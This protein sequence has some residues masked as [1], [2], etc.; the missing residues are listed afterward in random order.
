MLYIYRRAT[1][2][3]ARAL[4]NALNGRRWKGITIPMERKARPGDYVVCWGESFPNING[5]NVLNGTPIQSKYSDAIR[6]REAGVSTIE[7][8]RT[9]PV[10][11]PTVVTDPAIVHFNRLN[12]LIEEF[13]N[14]SLSPDG[15]VPRTEPMRVGVTQ[16]MDSVTG[17]RDTLDRP[18]TTVTPEVWLPR[19]NNHVG[20]N[21]LLRDYGFVPDYW[22]KKLDIVREYRIHSFLGHSIR[23]GMKTYRDGILDPHPWIRSWD[24]GW[25]IA[26]D[27]VTPRQKHRN[28]AH[29]AIRALGLDFGAV[30]IGELADGNLIVLEVNRAPGLEGGTITNYARAIRLWADG[31]RW[32][33]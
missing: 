7:V 24:G 18:I 25:R 20:G 31:E 2:N 16:L 26:Y 17:L 22:S 14:L 10:V 1:S 21:D 12:E 6:L 27:G 13:S 8:S 9:K 29:A 19:R 3:G 33:G 11:V 4:A 5:V 30:D 28:I 15:T 23:A 32:E